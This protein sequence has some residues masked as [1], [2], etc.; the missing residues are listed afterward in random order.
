MLRNVARSTGCRLAR[1]FLKV[2]V[3]ITQ[4]TIERHTSDIDIATFRQTRALEKLPK[5]NVAENAEGMSEAIC[6][7]YGMR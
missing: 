5:S 4:E 3:S 2:Q 6:N 1:Q 7:V